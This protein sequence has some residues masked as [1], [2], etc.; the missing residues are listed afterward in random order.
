MERLDLG[1]GNDPETLEELSRHIAEFSLG[2][3]ER[4]LGHGASL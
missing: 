2:G 4:V 1:I 3:M